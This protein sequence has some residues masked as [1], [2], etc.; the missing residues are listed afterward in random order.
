METWERITTVQ[1]NPG[2]RYR[3]S[4]ILCR[5][6]YLRVVKT[7]EGGIEITA[8]R[9]IRP[10]M[11]HI[12]EGIHFSV[13]RK[14]LCEYHVEGKWDE[15]LERFRPARTL[16]AEFIREKIPALMDGLR[17]EQGADIFTSTLEQLTYGL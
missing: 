6:E 10:P 5:D 13:D 9:T 12:Q 17:K 7:P 8:E 16:T 4:N 11:G 15:E 3:L 2:F 1:G 14:L